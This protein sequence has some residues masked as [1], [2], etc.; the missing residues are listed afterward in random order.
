MNSRIVELLDKQLLG[1]VGKNGSEEG[2]LVTGY[3]VVGGEA[4]VNW[5]GKALI[6]V[7]TVTTRT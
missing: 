4:R 1:N 2:E 3:Q 5:G 7:Q 6:E